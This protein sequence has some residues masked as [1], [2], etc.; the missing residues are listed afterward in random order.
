MAE[1]GTR[2]NLICK[3]FDSG[4]IAH[5]AVPDLAEDMLQVMP[6][7]PVRGVDRVLTLHKNGSCEITQ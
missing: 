7:K 3:A 5:E 6:N 4:D 2:A 1:A